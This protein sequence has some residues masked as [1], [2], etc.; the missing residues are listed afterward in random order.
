MLN[1]SQ[2]LEWKCCKDVNI[3]ALTEDDCFI[4]LFPYNISRKQ[5]RQVAHNIHLKYSYLKA[6]I[7]KLQK[8]HIL[9]LEIHKQ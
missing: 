2:V 3:I 8:G 1:V 7:K 4:C 5:G 9:V 6:N